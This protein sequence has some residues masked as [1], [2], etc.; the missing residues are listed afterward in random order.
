S[1][2]HVTLNPADTSSSISGCTLLSIHGTPCRGN[3][4]P[5][6]SR[7][8]SVLGRAQGRAHG[9]NGENTMRWKSLCGGLALLV[10]MVA[11]C[12][13]R[14]FITTDD[15]DHWKGVSA[16]ALESSPTIHAEPIQEIPPPP[17]S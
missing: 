6:R 12:K 10:A 5:A 4:R 15:Y 8:R 2:L 13:Q 9:S 17:P 7:W 3:G 14:L 16:A 1:S 11:G